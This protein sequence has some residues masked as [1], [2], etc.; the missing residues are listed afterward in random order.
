MAATAANLLEQLVEKLPESPTPMDDPEKRRE[1]VRGL[2][3]FLKNLA[4]PPPDAQKDAAHLALE[5]AIDEARKTGA[6][7]VAAMST[8]NA[9]INPDDLRA[10]LR[11]SVDAAADQA[12]ETTAAI[13]GLSGLGG[14]ESSEHTRHALADALKSSEAMKRLALRM[15]RIA[16]NKRRTRTNA[17]ASEVTNITTGSD[18]G[19]VLPHE[20]S[21]LN[22]PLLSL[23]FLRSFLEGTLLQ[24][25]LSG[26]EKEG[27]GPVVVLIDDSDSMDGPRSVFARA[28]ALAL[29]DLALSDRRSCRLIR[30]SHKLQATCDLRPGRDDTGTI[31]GFLAGETAGGTNFELP[32]LA[33]REA[34]ESA[35]TCSRADV[36]LIT[37]GEAELSASFLADW[38]ARSTKDGL[39][40]YAVHIGAEPPPVLRALTKDVLPLSS[41]VPEKLEDKLFGPIAG[42]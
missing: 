26:R 8:Y 23:D 25:G 42:L 6:A 38:H 37:D 9:A 27:R 1:E 15:R 22:D 16:M 2:L 12:E 30:F 24:Y 14:G 31:L 33:A 17:A 28:T 20:L 5:E 13:A 3:D 35:E 11:R 18:L 41:L 40:T 29:A 36:V 7:A 32:L 39:H 10:A 34:I 19:R 21:K 4:P